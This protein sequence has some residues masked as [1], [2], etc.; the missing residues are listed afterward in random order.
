MPAR[1]GCNYRS[2]LSAPVEIPSAQLEGGDRYDWDHLL[3]YI[4]DSVRILRPRACPPSPG[5]PTAEASQKSYAVLF[6]PR[7]TGFEERLD[8]ERRWLPQLEKTSVDGSGPWN[9]RISCAVWRNWAFQFAVYPTLIGSSRKKAQ[10]VSL[11][12]LRHQI[13]IHET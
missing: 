13:R 1:L 2:S 4:R 6:L 5:T 7:G 9:W 11:Q 8:R 12:F 3:T 10:S